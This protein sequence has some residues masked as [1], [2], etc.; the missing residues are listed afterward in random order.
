MAGE[1]MPLGKIV[2]V[3]DDVVQDSGTRKL[4]LRGAFT[5]LGPPEGESYPF[6]QSWMCV[7]AQLA[8]GRGSSLIEVKVVDASTGVAVFGSPAYQVQ[9]PGGQ[10]L[11]TVL[12]RMLDCLFAKQVVYLVQLFCQGVFI[13]DRRLTLL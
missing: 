9:F 2:Y 6:V 13:D 10:R 1:L 7:F 12:I 8:G 11:T 3:C 5:A 4:D